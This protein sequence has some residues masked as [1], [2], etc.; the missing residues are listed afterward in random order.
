[1]GLRACFQHDVERCFCRAA[2]ACEATVFDDYFA[3]AELAGLRA[4]GGA[5]AG[6]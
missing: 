3:Q 4:E 2:E 6:E 1:V 5:A